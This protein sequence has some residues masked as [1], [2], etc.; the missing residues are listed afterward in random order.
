VGRKIL[1]ATEEDTSPLLTEVAADNEQMLQEKLKQHPELIPVDEFG[2][3]SPLMVVGR[4]TRLPSGA[5]DLVGIAPGGEILLA[6]FKTGPQNPDFRAA[7]AQA[8]DYGSDLWGMSYDQFEDT[9]VRRFFAGPWC[10]PSSPLKKCD[11]LLTAADVAWGSSWPDE[12]RD[13]FVERITNA[14]A[15]GHLHYVV[16]AQAFTDS[17]TQT[18]RYLNHI[19]TSPKFFLVELIRFSNGSIEAFEART[20]LRP[21]AKRSRGQ[22]TALTEHD[23]LDQEPDDSFRHFMKEL[24]DFTGGIGLVHEWGSTGMSIRMRFSGHPQ[25]SS[26]AWLFPSNVKNGWMGLRY[27]TLGY[28]HR[29]LE[30]IPSAAPALNTY[31]TTVGMLDGAANAAASRL[32][33]YVFAPTKAQNNIEPIKEAIAALAESGQA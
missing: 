1:L 22:T 33:A 24:L 26:I 29:I 9:V 2:W 21:D 11:S 17:M 13:L 19:S 5:I 23:F 14:L 8:V 16:I 6:E 25:L 20:V 27:L 30:E 12:D 4:E 32:H 28:P 18:A 3:A 10:P 7:L 15:D 31:A